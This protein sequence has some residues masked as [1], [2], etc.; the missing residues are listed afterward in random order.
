MEGETQ[1]EQGIVLLERTGQRLGHGLVHL[2]APAHQCLRR[3]EDGGS[4]AAISNA[5]L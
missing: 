3:E 2:P 4:A 5:G 1:T